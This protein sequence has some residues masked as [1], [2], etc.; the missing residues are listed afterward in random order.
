MTPPILSSTTESSSRPGKE[1]SLPVFHK[2]DEMKQIL[3][4]AAF[5]VFLGL[6]FQSVAFALQT[7]TGDLNLDSLLGKINERAK[8]DPDGFIQQLSQN[9][10][11]PEED[12]R[13]AKERHGLSYGDTYM[14]TALA[15]KN[16]RR[17]GD[18]AAEYEQNQGKG[19]GVMAMNMGIRPGSP[20][21]KELKAGARGSVDHMKTMAKDKKRLQEQEMEKEREHGP[22]NKDEGQGKHQ[23]KGKKK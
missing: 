13:Q 10:G 20:E 11:I 18:V 16:N 17:V 9:Y 23:G 15:R 7:S 21:F 5:L 3:T 22:E 12:V 2:D 6:H 1:D 8:A 19:W 14:A 4:V